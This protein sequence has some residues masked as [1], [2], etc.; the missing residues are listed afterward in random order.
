MKLFTTL[1]RTAL[2]FPC[3][4]IVLSAGNAAG[5]QKT[6]K[7]LM[8]GTWLLESVYDQTQDGVK[9]D[10]WGPGVKGI[11]IFD[12]NGHFSWQIMAANR[13]KSEGTNGR[14]PVGPVSCFFGTYTVDDG[15]K[16]LTLHVERCTFPQWDG[17]EGTWNVAFPTE[18]ELNLTTTKPI[19][20]PSFGPFIPHLNFK[21]A[22]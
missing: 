20:D 18:N 6:L 13:P 22:M 12:E 16:I 14:T 21:R 4:G 19:Q 10:P 5:Q 11:A 1:T 2:A 7:E 9:H 8:V 3:L 17:T 15:A